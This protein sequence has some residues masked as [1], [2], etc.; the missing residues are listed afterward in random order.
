MKLTVIG[1]GSSGN[2]YLLQNGAKS[3]ALII[4]AGI[5]LSEVK[6]ALKW[7]ISGLVGAVVS[8]R[9]NDHAKYAAD[10][11]KSGIRVMALRDV[12]EAKK[13]SELGFTK[14]IDANKG[15]AVGGFKILT[16]PVSH[17]VPCLGFI[18][19]HEE[20]GNML[21]VTDTM[22]IDFSVPPMDHILIEANYAEDIAISNVEN[23]HIP[24]ALLP[25]LHESH[26]ELGTTLQY[27][28]ESDMSS[29]KNIV[30]IHLSS[31]NSDEARFV[32][33][34][35]VATGIPTYAA[36]AGLEVELN[37]LPF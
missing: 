7:K 2:C 12:L 35:S 32:R 30:L 14:A 17:D 33:E 37:K 4:E 15:Y 1:S 31:G 25:R 22:S 19:S 16:F 36:K 26:M 29:C 24:A 11:V 5:S 10:Y 18:I 21:F 8:H 9:H 23:G 6:K 34:V 28:R 27:L 13:I 3:E 20:M